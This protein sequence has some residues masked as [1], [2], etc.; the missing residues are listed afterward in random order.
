MLS[1]ETIDVVKSTVP[2]LAEHGEAITGNFYER[3]FTNNPELKNVFNQVNQSRGDQRRALAD[4][5]F[6]YA[7]NIDNLEALLPAVGR[8][9]HKHAS[10]G[11]KPEQYPI[12]G[13]NLLKAI[14]DVLG[15]PDDHAALA[16]WGEAY[17]VLADVF[18]GAEENIYQENEAA[19]GGWRGFKNFVIDEIKTET[20]EV[21]SFYLRPEDGSD[22][23]AFRGGQYLGLKVS[24]EGSEFEEIRQYSLSGKPEQNRLRISTKAEE[25]GLVS[26]YLH[27]RS[28]G[29]VVQLQPPAGVFTLDDNAKK[30][31]FIAGGV[32][33]TP[34]MGMLYEALAKGTKPEDILFVQCARALEYKVFADELKAL[35]Q[36]AGFHYKSQLDQGT[37]GDHEGYL[38]EQVLAKWLD[39]ADLNPPETSVYFCGP[40]PFMKALNQCFKSI[41][42]NPEQINYEVFGPT[43]SLD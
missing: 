41:G 16:A 33:I 11:I 18:I 8:I 25:K 12:V 15:L 31:V 37:E 30:H 39:E 10:L 5:V 32:G 14:Q 43:E 9:A 22:V 28:I 26:N 29:D 34:L 6:A 3:L 13:E 27:A 38:N 35:Q 1:Q 4:A 20:P 24:P 7:Q 40:K 36:S 42:F 17:G 21:K 19:K 2:L 23:P